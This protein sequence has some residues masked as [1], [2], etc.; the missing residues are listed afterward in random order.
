MLTKYQKREQGTGKRIV[1]ENNITPEA[2]EVPSQ[3]VL[4]KITYLLSSILT[5][6]E[7]SLLSEKISYSLS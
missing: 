7:P 2:G 5:T 1:L 6:E 4:Q 3:Q